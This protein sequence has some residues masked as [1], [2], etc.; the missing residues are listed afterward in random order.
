MM[1]IVQID[2]DFQIISAAWFAYLRTP[3][4]AEISVTGQAEVHA[5]LLDALDI[6]LKNSQ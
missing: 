3:I 2:A 4:P 1:L 5:C 6:Q